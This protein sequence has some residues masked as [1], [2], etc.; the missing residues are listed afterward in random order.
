MKKYRFIGIAFFILVLVIPACNVTPSQIGQTQAPLPTIIIELTSST[1]SDLP[2]TEADVSRVSVE[3]ARVALES[4][5]AI[6][7]DVRSAETY[8]AGH[9]PGAISIPLAEF[10]N[11]IN[12]IALEKDQWIITYCT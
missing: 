2:R 3:R 7:V 9:I 6:I 5:G 8:A 10:E 11:N 4:G 1:M 12:G